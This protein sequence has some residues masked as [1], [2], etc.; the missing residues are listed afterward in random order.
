MSW[1]GGGVVVGVVRTRAED[2]GRLEAHD[3]EVRP[4]TST[5][6]AGD[7]LETTTRRRR[8]RGAHTSARQGADASEA[9]WS[10][11]AT[12]PQAGHAREKGVG[13]K[14]F[15]PKPRLR[16]KIDFPF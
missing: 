6:V 14:R 5:A 10:E 7:A 16:F 8:R 2:A 1:G 12:G 15:G 3:G 9:G 13:P 4:R 11:R